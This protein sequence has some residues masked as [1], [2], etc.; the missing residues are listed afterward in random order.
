MTLLAI[1]AFSFL[2]S[3]TPMP[4]PMGPVMAAVTPEYERVKGF[5]LRSAEDTPEELYAFRPTPGVRS[6]GQI[7]GHIAEIQ[8][9]FCAAAKNEANPQPEEFEKTKSTKAELV[10]SLRASFE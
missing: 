2:G 3:Q 9:V 6:F 4:A 8:F 5:L 7:V 1:A 10:K